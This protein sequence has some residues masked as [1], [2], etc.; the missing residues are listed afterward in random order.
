MHFTD[1]DETQTHPWAVVAKYTI[2]ALI[3]AVTLFLIVGEL[4]D[5]SDEFEIVIDRERGIKITAVSG[6][7]LDE[8]LDDALAE[9]ARKVSDILKRRDFYELHSRDL[10]VALRDTERAD[11]DPETLT[12]YREIFWELEGPF[13]LPGTLEKMDGR[14]IAALEDLESSVLRQGLQSTLMAE[15]WQQSMVQQGIFRPRLIDAE[16][17]LLTGQDAT[18]A[19]EYPIFYTCAG[20]PLDNRLVMVAIE[21]G[22]EHGA[23]RAGLE[24]LQ[25]FLEADPFRADLIG[26]DGG[27]GADFA[28]LLAGGELKLGMT[29]DSYEK[30]FEVPMGSGEPDAPM[31]ARVQVGALK[32]P[33]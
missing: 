31:P 25:G 22:T 30:L 1:E 5:T 9:N 17:T 2:P 14:L 6:E 26:C 16:I 12:R 28:G 27:R 24:P 23:V 15:I 4:S 10:T 3:A 32:R 21:P 7:T 18:A 8:V 20:S 29:Q 33:G 19:D 11:L 13:A